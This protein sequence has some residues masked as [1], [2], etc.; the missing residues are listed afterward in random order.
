MLNEGTDFSQEGFVNQTMLIG[1]GGRAAP[2]RGRC[3]EGRG[4]SR[5]AA[6]PGRLLRHSPQHSPLPWELSCLS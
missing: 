6:L 5:A 1:G 4:R 3:R 2:R